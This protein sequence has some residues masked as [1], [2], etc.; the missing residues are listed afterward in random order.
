[1]KGAELSNGLL[2]IDLR[3]LEPERLVKRIEIGPAVQVKSHG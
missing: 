3:R 2:S 1:V